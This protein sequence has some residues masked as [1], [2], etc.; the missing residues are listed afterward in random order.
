[1]NTTGTIYGILS[2]TNK[3][4]VG[5][6]WNLL[7]RWKSYF[8]LGCKSQTYLFNSLKFHGVN[9]H[10]FFVIEEIKNCDQ[11]ILN[12]KELFHWRSYINN[13]F[14]SLNI[15][16]PKGSKGKLSESTRQKI[17]IKKL[18][19][20]SSEETKKLLSDLMRG[21]RIGEKNPMYGKIGA[22]KGKKFSLESRLKMSESHKGKIPYNKGIPLSEERKQKLINANLGKKMTNE[23]K[24]KIS[25]KNSGINNCSAKL[26]EVQVREI[27]SIM[28]QKYNISELMAKYKVAKVT[29]YKIKSFKIWK[30]I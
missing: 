12:E 14:G 5:Q 16:E 6:T 29:L 23:T 17:S 13:G 2:P 8:K 18:G 28:N 7:R 4:Y 30:N 21:K 25:K 15:R 24:E 3:I 27:R 11:N 1:M 20:K 22:N 26:T 9:N 10:K 19:K